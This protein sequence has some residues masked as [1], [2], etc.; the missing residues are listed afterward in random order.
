MSTITQTLEDNVLALMAPNFASLDV[1]LLPLPE[2]VAGYE[3]AKD[4]PQVWVAL[5]NAKGGEVVTTDY[6]TQLQMRTF[7][8]ILKSRTLRGELGIYQLS[9][10]VTA[11]LLGKPVDDGPGTMKFTQLQNNGEADGVHGYSMYFEVPVWVILEQFDTES[12]NGPNL[13]RADFNEN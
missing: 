9:D 2:N 7:E 11:S 10:L 12:L 3:R 6:V 8:I 4:R 5:N 1:D 13:V